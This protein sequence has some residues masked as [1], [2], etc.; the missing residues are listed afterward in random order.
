MSLP[1]LVQSIRADYLFMIQAYFDESGTQSGSPVT[2]VAG[3][4]FESE[5]C[6]RLDA[7]WEAALS[8]FG[9]SHFHMTDCANGAGLFRAMPVSKRDQLARRLIGIIKRRA[10][11]GIVASAR[12]TDVARFAKEHKEE[13]AYILCLCW[14]VTGVAEWA[15]E[16]RYAGNIAYFFEA[17]HRLARKANDAMMF[18]GLNPTLRQGS[19]YVAHS[20]ITKQQARPIQAADILAWQ[21]HKEWINRFG[22][23][24]RPRRLDF[25]SLLELPHKV[26]H[27][28][29]EHLRALN[30]IFPSITSSPSE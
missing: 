1:E 6:L 2:C 22:V 3:Y 30:A 21:W 29:E 20:F 23:R 17:G 10:A 12:P 15:A 16:R 28:T 18:L 27:L 25:E 5:Q 7:E 9:V 4:L 19:R 11:I 24:R 8:D 26:G 13:A 14:C